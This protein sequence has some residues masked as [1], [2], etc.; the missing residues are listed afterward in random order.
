MSLVSGLKRVFAPSPDA[1]PIADRAEIDARFR[2][3]RL[4]TIASLTFGYGMAYTCRLGMSVVKKP[5]IDGG[6]YSATELG[7]IGAAWKLSY[8]F[9]KLFNGFIAD[10]ASVRKLIPLGLGLSALVN[11]AMGANSL[12]A[13]AVALWALNGWFQG[14][15]APSC[16]IC[17]TDWFSG[18]ER[19]TAYGV[20]SAAHSIGEGITFWGT[21]VLVGYSSW[22]VAFWAPGIVCVVVAVWLYTLLRDRPQSE[23]L[24]SI[25]DWKRSHGEE[26]VDG[27]KD[28]PDDDELTSQ[29]TFQMR[30]LKNPAVWIC[31]LASASMYI[32]RYAVNEWG[33]LYLQEEHGL[34]RTLSGVIVGVNTVGGILG[35]FAYGWI[36]DRFFQSRRPPVT[37]IFGAL[38]VLSLWMLFLGPQGNATIITV[39]MFLY[40]FTLSGILAVLGGL[41]AV[42]MEPRAAGAAMGLVGCFS[43]LGAAAGDVAS[44]MLIEA[45]A[46]MVDGVRV[47]DFSNAVI[48]WIGPS[49]VSM[50]L[51]ATLWKVQTRD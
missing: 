9:G 46:S 28:D 50:L 17:L 31:G 19:G 12:I 3:L 42:D 48:L 20:W 18:R 43:Y 23:G 25:R 41:F 39:G 16:V 10:H 21:A 36:S 15:L 8:G 35:S 27:N 30:L 22:R 11:L 24:P 4:R 37:L 32:T 13:V 38:E 40:G 5:L 45:G 51:A 6:V 29:L 2:K 44:G 47:Y 33:M 14:F 34:A 1:P 26:P 7:W 49:I